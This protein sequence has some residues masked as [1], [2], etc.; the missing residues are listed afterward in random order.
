MSS[1]VVDPNP[2]NC[3]IERMQSRSFLR[4]VRHERHS[5]RTAE[6]CGLHC[7]FAPSR[8]I[9][10]HHPMSRSKFVRLPQRRCSRLRGILRDEICDFDCAV[11]DF[12]RTLPVRIRTGFVVVQTILQRCSDKWQRAS[13]EIALAPDQGPS[14]QCKLLR[15]CGENKVSKNSG[16]VCI[17]RALSPHYLWQVSPQNPVNAIHFLNRGLTSFTHEKSRIVRQTLLGPC[18]REYGHRSRLDR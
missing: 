6:G 2:F 1:L 13:I 10:F 9:A 18:R 5:R 14:K 17:S 16:A 12:D 11:F 8:R 15:S 7:R 3:I 4:R